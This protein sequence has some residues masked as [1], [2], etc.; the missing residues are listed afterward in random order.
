MIYYAHLDQGGEGCDY[1]IGCGH[2][3]RK[4]KTTGTMDEAEAEL[5]A[6]I[7]GEYTSETRTL[8][9]A[10]ILAVAETREVDMNDM[11]SIYKEVE[12]KNAEAEIVR[13]EKS[14]REQFEALK[15]KFEK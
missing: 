11:K 8:A 15:K 5:R 10:K 12:R 1:T 2:E 9:H 14:E 3:L 7:V 4:L 13:Q 6:L